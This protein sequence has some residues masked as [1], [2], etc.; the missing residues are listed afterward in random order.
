MEKRDDPNKR[1][2]AAA[3][4]NLI[5]SKLSKKEAIEVLKM[6]GAIYDQ[7]LVSNFVPSAP[8]PMGPPTGGRGGRKAGIG[9]GR[10]STGTKSPSEKPSLEKRSLNTQLALVKQKI[11]EEIQKTG[12]KAL[13]EQHDL[14]LQRNDLL[15]RL[16]ELKEGSSRQSDDV[17]GQHPPREEEGQNDE[18]PPSE[19]KGS[20]DSPAPPQGEQ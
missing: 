19:K 13:P 16:A 5:L 4:I 7:H 15:R 9:R 1:F 20:N 8:V 11:H 17:K 10:G 14:V 2:I 3:E 6:V 18:D 12:N